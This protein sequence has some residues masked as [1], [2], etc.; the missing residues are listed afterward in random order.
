MNYRI[1]DEL[2][3]P[4]YLKAISFFELVPKCPQ[5]FRKQQNNLLKKEVCIRIC[6]NNNNNNNESKGINVEEFILTELCEF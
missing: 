6:N 5:D 2:Q 3:K 1:T 4:L